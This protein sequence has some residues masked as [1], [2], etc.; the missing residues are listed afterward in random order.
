M[1]IGITY[2]GAIGDVFSLS[3]R[4]QIKGKDIKK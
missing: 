3:E 1:K 4:L 2:I